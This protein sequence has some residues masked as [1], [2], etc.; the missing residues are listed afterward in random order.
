MLKKVFLS[1]SIAT[2]L[3]LTGCAK[4]GM[5][6]NTMGGNKVDRV[7][8]QGSV[9]WQQKEIIDNK[10]VAI[11]TGVGVGAVGGALLSSKNRGKGAIIGGVL[12]GVAGAVVGNEVEAYRTVLRGDDGI[13]Y[14]CYLEQPLAPGSRLEF[15][16]DT[17]GK[18]KNVNIISQAPMEQPQPRRYQQEP[19]RR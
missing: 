16:I 19:M 10:E 15:T 7:F 12:G 5:A 4:E 3:L 8:K 18:L 9:S 13:D 1:L 11:L 6:V 2:T 14:Q 17:D